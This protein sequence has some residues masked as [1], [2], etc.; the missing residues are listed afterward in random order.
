MGK[1][2]YIR[3]FWVLYGCLFSK[4][5]VSVRKSIKANCNNE[6]DN[7]NNRDYSKGIH[8]YKNV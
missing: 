8:F 2:E 7:Q 3:I 6:E 1:Q 5:I 4:D